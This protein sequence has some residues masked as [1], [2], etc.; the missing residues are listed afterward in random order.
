MTDFSVARGLWDCNESLGLPATRPQ[1][2]AY[3]SSSNGASKCPS[4]DRLRLL[5]RALWI[6]D[7]SLSLF[8]VV[9]HYT[10]MWLI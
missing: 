7:P 8:Q 10:T 5:P 9:Q 4:F 6:E 2:P 3:Q 1:L